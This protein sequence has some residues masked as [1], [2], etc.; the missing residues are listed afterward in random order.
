MVD[1]KPDLSL[2]APK[3]RENSDSPQMKSVDHRPLAFS[4][5]KEFHSSAEGLENDS[6]VKKL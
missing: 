5:I 6:S 2:I 1:K 3:E 4:T